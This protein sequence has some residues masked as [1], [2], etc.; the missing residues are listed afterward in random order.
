MAYDPNQCDVKRT[1]QHDPKSSSL[2]SSKADLP[3]KLTATLTT[4]S[5]AA[6]EDVVMDG[7]AEGRPQGETE[8]ED[9][10]CSETTRASQ[11]T[12][13]ADQDTHDMKRRKISEYPHLATLLDIGGLI[14]A[15]GTGLVYQYQQNLVL[16]IV[17]IFA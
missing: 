17:S 3:W 8:G 14:A 4:A 11:D 6:E 10:G 16:K 12:S 2:A 5:N 1:C 15:G 9:T 7:K 13:T